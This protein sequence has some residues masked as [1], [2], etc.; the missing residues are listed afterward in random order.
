ME[1][2]SNPRDD[3]AIAAEL[4]RLHDV[5]REM[6]AAATREEVFR[7]A[8][9]AAS[10]LLGFEY[11]TIRKHDPGR[12]TLSPVAVSPAL[13][14]ADGERRPY[15][16]GESVQWEAFD[17]G[18][19]RVYQRVAAIDDD[20]ERNG[21]GS[22]VVVPLGEFGVLTLGSPIERA[23]SEGDV[24]LARVFGANLETAIDRVDELATLS[25]RT[26]RLR[27]RNDRLDRLGGMIA[28]EFRNPVNIALGV[29]HGIDD[30]PEDGPHIDAA[31]RAVE[32]VDRLT[33]SLL[34]LVDH[35]SIG[36]A[37]APVRVDLLAATTFERR[38]P[39][40]AAIHRTAL[41]TV[42]ANERRLETLLERVVENAIVHAGPTPT[43]WIGP[44]AE[45]GFYVAD[46]GP[47]FGDETTESLTAYRPAN[48]GDTGGLGLT[49]VTDIV[50]A[51]GWNLSLTTSRV[52]GARIE[53][54]TDSTAAG[55]P[56]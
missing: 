21:D 31:L 11:N 40:G 16:R 7:I 10:D 12:D 17:E 52:G 33:E 42:E 46:D 22:M 15:D 50:A 19:I 49:I 28:H 55:E 8:T 25:E 39:D 24:E 9:A 4:R 3:A 53:I 6:T 41:I 18:E 47:G 48:G 43:V 13:K 29:L 2:G 45:G 37:T 1:E 34:D 20:A 5:T 35:D 56:I 54:R 51:H 36:G 14:T 30:P 38:C 32:R 27:R 44:L 23:V 26:T